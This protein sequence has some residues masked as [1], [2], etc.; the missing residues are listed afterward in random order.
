MVDQK[1]KYH[2]KLAK[3]ERYQAQR[4][5]LRKKRSKSRVSESEVE[6]ESEEDRTWSALEND[7]GQ[8]ANLDIYRFFSH[9]F[10]TEG[11]LDPAK[12]TGPLRLDNASAGTKRAVISRARRHGLQ[13]YH[14]PHS[15]GSV[16]C[17]G[18][19]RDGVIALT[20]EIRDEVVGASE[21][22]AIKN[23]QALFDKH[24]GEHKVLADQVRQQRTDEFDDSEPVW[25]LKHCRG[26]FVLQ[27]PEICSKFPR[28]L[29]NTLRI[30][31]RLVGTDEGLALVA[32]FD[33]GV[34][35]GTMYLADS[36]ET[37]QG[38][39]E[40]EERNMNAD[41][42]IELP[43]NTSRKRKTPPGSL[44]SGRRKKRTSGSGNNINSEDES[45]LTLHVSFRGRKN[46][47]GNKDIFYMPRSGTIEFFDDYYCRLKGTVNLPG[48]GNVTFD[49]WK[50]QTSKKGINE[51]RRWSAFS[52]TNFQD[53][54]KNKGQGQQQQPRNRGGQGVNNGQRA[55]NIASPEKGTMERPFTIGSP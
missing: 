13:F 48:I 45:S 49:G 7:P 52:E 39:C 2:R 23:M 50:I 34:C 6:E 37:L 44:G 54:Q 38:L 29:H 55:G 19:E 32:K 41:S 18:V 25:K 5:T 46:L 22:T 28:L 16:L 3:W 26:L 40:D 21:K 4:Q 33:F 36:T 47:P 11:K 51:P 9:Y 10:L 35:S 27:S 12:T 42:D 20:Y 53:E 8:Q 14:S 17:V 43:A 15:A 1:Q 31:Q 30:S 24:M